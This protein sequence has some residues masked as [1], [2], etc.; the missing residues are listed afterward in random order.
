[1]FPLVAED[2]RKLH[3]RGA[4]ARGPVVDRE[5]GLSAQAVLSSS[6]L[7]ARIV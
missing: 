7:R 2:G 4:G 3:E 5:G 1:M 6:T